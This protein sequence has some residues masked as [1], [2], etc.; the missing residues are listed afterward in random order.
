MW[1][2]LPLYSTTPQTYSTIQLD[3][4]Q[5]QTCHNYL[6]SQCRSSAPQ[7]RDNTVPRTNL[8]TWSN[9]SNSEA[10]TYLPINPSSSWLQIPTQ[11]QP[12]TQ[13]VLLNNQDLFLIHFTVRLLSAMTIEESIGEV[14]WTSKVGHTTQPGL[15]WGEMVETW[16][17]F[18]QEGATDKV[19]ALCSSALA[20]SQN[21][22]RQDGM[23]ESTI[24]MFHSSVSSLLHTWPDAFSLSL[25]MIGE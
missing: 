6:N 14:Y 11:Y 17:V 2:E 20:K 16:G 13:S 22:Y 10:V 25:S 9:Q 23:E 8:R 3:L 7:R 19:M 1:Y 5:L 12:Q 15:L 4:N 24:T 18:L 21:N